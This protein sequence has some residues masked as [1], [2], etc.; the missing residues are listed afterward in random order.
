MMTADIA[1]QPPM[2]TLPQT[3]LPGWL[4]RPLLRTRSLDAILCRRAAD[5]VDKAGMDRHLPAEGLCLDVGAGF[6][7]IVEVLLNRAQ[8]RRCILID[9]V[10]RPT[11][12]L[13]R[14]LSRAAPGRWQFLTADGLRL[15]F[16]DASFDAAWMAFV[17]HHVSYDQQAHVLEE[18][19]RVVKAQG[20]FLLLE[21]T[22]S[23]PAERRVTERADRRL[24]LEAGRPV[25]CYRSPQAWRV[26]LHQAGFTLVEE[27]GFTRIFPRASLAP[28]PHRAFVC[29]C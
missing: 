15:P 25:H 19:R 4:L 9:P 12:R 20:M 28:V 16:A 7:H 11:M 14:R 18:V 26:L 29:R 24:N 17:L 13:A 3:L 2:S 6:G 22:P 5:I 10:W 27:I 21:D 8:R 1:L 23:S